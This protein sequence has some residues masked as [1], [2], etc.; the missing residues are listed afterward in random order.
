MKISSE[1]IKFLKELRHKLKNQETDCQ[2]APRYWGVAETKREYGVDADYGY[3]GYI[4][5]VDFETY[6]EDDEDGLARFKEYLIENCED[7][8]NDDD[9]HKNTSL[10]AE[11]NDYDDIGEMYEF[12]CDELDIDSS[13]I[14]LV[15]YREIESVVTQETGC[16]LTKEACQKHIELN[17]YHYNNP[18]T[19]AMTAWRNPEFERLMNIIETMEFEEEL[20][21]D[22]IYV[23][24]YR[25]KMYENNNRRPIYIKE[26]NAKQVLTSEAKRI[27]KDECD[28]LGWYDMTKDEQE[29][30][31]NKVK[32]RFE[33]K[34]FVSK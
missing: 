27:A 33:I 10:V 25:G 22:V 7:D 14:T 17:H 23:L 16:F 12:A 4:V 31:I 30:M 21:E 8:Y 3:D 15:Y 34:E 20:N 28:T 6:F 26:S 13:E 11:L 32:E 29:K 19:Y 5:R 9:E 1:D 2:A 18:H 24:Y